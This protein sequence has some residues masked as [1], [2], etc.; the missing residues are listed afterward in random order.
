MLSRGEKCRFR[1]L[2][3]I[4]PDRQRTLDQITPELEFDG[5][6]TFLSDEG[7]RKDVYAIIEV[8]GVASPLIVPVDRLK[9][10][11]RAAGEQLANPAPR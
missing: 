4:C 10:A 7:D 6:I 8:E 2:D 3:V 1:L 9:P 5:R 11:P